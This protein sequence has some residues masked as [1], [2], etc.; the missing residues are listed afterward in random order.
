MTTRQAVYA[1]IDGERA[2]QDAK[3]GGRNHDNVESIANFILY[4][5][6]YLNQAKAALVDSTHDTA[7]LD[8]I[9]KVAALAVVCMEVHGAPGR[10]EA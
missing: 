7:A 4:I 2:Y 10:K 5:E 3:W 8:V 9:R 6:R 1:A